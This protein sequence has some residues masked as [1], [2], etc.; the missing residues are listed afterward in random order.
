MGKHKLDPNERPEGIS[1]LCRAQLERD[2]GKVT[3]RVSPTTVI[4]VPPEKA[5]EKYAEWYRKN[6][7]NVI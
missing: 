3:L 6:R 4:L 7:L 2:A 5:N 1:N